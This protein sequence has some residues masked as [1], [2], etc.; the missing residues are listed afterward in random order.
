[1]KKILF[2]TFVF[3]VISNNTGYSQFTK[4]SW[5]AGILI[6]GGFSSPGNNVFFNLNILP[7]YYIE[8]GFS[9]EPQFDINVTENIEPKFN[10]IGNLS[11]T[12]RIE[13]SG[14]APYLKAG[15]GLSN[16]VTGTGYPEYVYYYHS[17]KFD[18]GVF[19]SA[20]GLKFLVNKKIA[21][22]GE[23]NYKEYHI[24]DDEIP[25]ENSDMTHLSFL[26]GLSF[27]F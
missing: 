18:I 2:L 26:G 22:R 20:L 10:F 21:L 19:N 9:I 24:N 3:L 4:N 13:N 27:L 12:F 1:M 14:F 7:A 11:Y 8:K 16:S 25:I 5:E 6:N 15:Y 23:L 17:D